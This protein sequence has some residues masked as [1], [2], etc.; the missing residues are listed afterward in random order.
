M[1]PFRRADHADAE[2]LLDAARARLDTAPAQRHAATPADATAP[3]AYATGPN[4]PPAEPLAALLA[5]AAGPVRA[6]E[7]A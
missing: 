6:G 4:V 2:R 3:E 7:L 1:N 5:A